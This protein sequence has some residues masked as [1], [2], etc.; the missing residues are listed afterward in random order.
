MCPV[1]S[2]VEQPQRVVAVG[3]IR[4]ITEVGMIT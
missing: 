2:M 3:T 4:W 1:A